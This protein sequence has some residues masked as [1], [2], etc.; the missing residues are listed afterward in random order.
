VLLEGA[1]YRLLSY[2]NLQTQVRRLLLRVTAAMVAP[3]I[4]VGVYQAR[5]GLAGLA[6]LVFSGDVV[7]AAA[8]NFAVAAPAG[9]V[10]IDGVF[11]V[12]QG[13]QSA[14]GSYSI[15]V[16]TTPTYDLLN[17]NIVSGTVPATFTTVLAA[18]AALPATFDPRATP[19][20]QAVPS[21]LNTA[22]VLRLASF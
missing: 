16:Y 20:G 17:Q 7:L 6:R 13:R 21:T 22:P 19:T 1:A 8:G 18:N 5:S 9:T 4:R 14:A 15:R 11:Y 10:L 12:L 3:T 2:G